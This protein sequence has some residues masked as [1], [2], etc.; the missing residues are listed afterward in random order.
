MNSPEKDTR[1]HTEKSSPL[2]SVIIPTFSEGPTLEVA[3]R[4]IM[5]Q[6]H[7]NLEILIVDDGSTDDTEEISQR[8]AAEDPR[9]R[10]LQCPYKDPKRR[11]IRGNNISV[12]YLARNF[13]MDESHGEWITFQDADD[14]SV[15]NRI[16]V[17]LQL[18]QK[19][20]ATLVTT[21]CVD[22]KDELLH[23]RFDMERFLRDGKAVVI[24][25]AKHVERA[26]RVKGFFMIEP[27]H[28]F[29]PFVFKRRTP[30]FNRFFLGTQETYLGA[31][32]SMFFKRE[33]A[34][35]VRFRKRD[36]RVWPAKSGRGVGRDFVFNVAE[37][38][39][40]SWS[41]NYPLYLWRT[42]DIHTQDIWMEK[43]LV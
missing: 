10:Y 2:V 29:I 37:T 16:E 30:F 5:E 12:G 38:F 25:P 35:K 39:K 40:N 15:P 4:S 34:E 27:F 14:A 21:S 33:V 43:Y 23:K 31:D 19:H 26:L 18:A 7:R 9:V 17:Q 42:R 8:L 6:T 22:F 11:D 36:E 41:F 32:N 28:R 20:N 13:G 1:T 24:E 3:V